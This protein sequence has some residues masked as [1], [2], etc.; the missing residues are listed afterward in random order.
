LTENYRKVSSICW[1]NFQTPSVR[2]P[3]MEKMRF[4][5]LLFLLMIHCHFPISRSRHHHRDHHHHQHLASSSGFTRNFRSSLSSVLR[6]QNKHKGYGFCTCASFIDASGPSQSAPDHLLS[7]SP[8]N[9]LA[10]LR[11]IILNLIHQIDLAINK[12]RFH[13]FRFII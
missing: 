9:H 3:R 7:H 1:V 2:Q 5:I 12:F 13:S 6:N 8:R 11:F 10:Y 4:P